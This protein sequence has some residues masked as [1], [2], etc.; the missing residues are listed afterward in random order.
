MKVRIKSTGQVVD[1]V[2]TAD[3]FLFIMCGLVEEVKPEP[4]D[5]RKQRKNGTAKWSAG[6]T[7]GHD[8][9]PCITAHCDACNAYQL[10][11]ENDRLVDAKTGRIPKSTLPQAFIE[12]CGK[13]EK[14]PDDVIRA[15]E[16]VFDV[17]ME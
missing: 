3:T 17:V 8:R 1:I 12:H 16:K 13:R 9:R 11:L 15:Y 10:F 14:V 6:F 5:W 2:A 7:S 4:M